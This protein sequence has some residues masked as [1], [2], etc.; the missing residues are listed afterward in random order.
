[1]AFS[2]FNLQMLNLWIG[3][4]RAE[5]GLPTIIRDLGYKPEWIE[6]GFPNSQKHVVKPELIISSIIQQHSILF[7]W[8]EGNNT[9]NDQLKRYS[10]IT[11][12]DIKAFLSSAVTD[13]HDICIIG[14]SSNESRILIGI[15]QGQYTFPVL[16]VDDDGL[17]LKLNSFCIPELNDAFSPKMYISQ[18]LIPTQLIPFDINS[19][20]WEIAERIIVQVITYIFNNKTFFTVDEVLKDSA[21][22]WHSFCSPQE[23]KHIRT[24]AIQVIELA[25]QN[26]FQGYFQRNKVRPSINQSPTWDIICTPYKM[27]LDKRSKEYHKLK[28]LFANFLE[29]LKTNGNKTRQ[30]SYLIDY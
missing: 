30:L 16:L 7:E 25:S 18:A 9:D 4:C 24:I 29:E 27:P 8:K 13:F 11:S 26:E 20:D 17:E 12:M 6:L 23:K 1:M 15:N 2:N 22:I 19:K 28:S 21:P 3:L 5:A 14:L 10:E